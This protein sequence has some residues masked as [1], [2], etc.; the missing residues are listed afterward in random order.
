MGLFIDFLALPTASPISC[1]SRFTLHASRLRR[2]LC[3]TKRILGLTFFLFFGFSRFATAWNSDYVYGLPKERRMCVQRDGEDGILFRSIASD[4]DCPPGFRRYIV[5]FAKEPRGA[6]ALVP[7]A[8]SLRFYPPLVLNWPAGDNFSSNSLWHFTC[9]QNHEI[10]PLGY[11]L[12][13]QSYRGEITFEGREDCQ[14]AERRAL[15]FCREEWAG[16]T[17]LENCPLSW[18]EEYENR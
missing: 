14:A 8:T 4:E 3:R 9:I 17:L 10:E 6:M 1:A 11:K 13:L 16:A 15:K 7:T 18:G 12:A 2:R 5:I